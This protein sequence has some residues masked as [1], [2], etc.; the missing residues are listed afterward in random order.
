[1][2]YPFLEV[3]MQSLQGSFFQF[4]SNTFQLSYVFR[5]CGGLFVCLTATIELYF[6]PTNKSTNNFIEKSI[7]L[8]VHRIAYT[9]N[10]KLH[11]KLYISAI[12]E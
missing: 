9:K 1:M 3:H 4:Q 2:W 12:V 5:S 8:Y 11:A 10:T 7:F 6:K